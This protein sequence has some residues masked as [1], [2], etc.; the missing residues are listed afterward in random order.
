[1]FGRSECVTVLTGRLSAHSAPERASPFEAFPR[2]PWPPTRPAPLSDVTVFAQ[3]SAAGS[4][5]PPARACL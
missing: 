1:M 2:T 3:S 4:R 5:A